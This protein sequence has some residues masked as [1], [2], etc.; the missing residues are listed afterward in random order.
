[1]LLT[2]SKRIVVNV[3]KWEPLSHAKEG[4]KWWMRPDTGQIHQWHDLDIQHHTKA[5]ELGIGSK[6]DNYQSSDEAVENGYIRG[7]DHPDIRGES[8]GTPYIHG[9]LG[10]MLQ[11]K[12]KIQNHIA[13][14]L[15][16]GRSV[17]VHVEDV[18]A[19]TIATPSDHA[20]LWKDLK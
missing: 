5:G 19:R 8:W 4:S 15:R 10:S 9:E 2:G 3:V 7:G 6:G 20:N 13:K 14:Q 16:A 11:N 12:T 1:M 17:N 18:A